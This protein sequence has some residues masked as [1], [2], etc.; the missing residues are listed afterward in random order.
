MKVE[1]STNYEK[2]KFIDFNRSLNEGNVKKL[3][4]LNS[5]DDNYKYF[6]I[7]VS[8]D[9]EIIDGQHRFEACKRTEKPI[10]YLMKDENRAP[11]VEDVNIVNVAGRK[12]TTSDKLV[13]LAKAGDPVAMEVMEACELLD[14]HFTPMCVLSTSLGLASSGSVKTRVQEHNF[15]GVDINFAIDCLNTL[16]DSRIFDKRKERTVVTILRI[17]KNNGLTFKEVVFALSEKHYMLT[18]GRPNMEAQRIQF[19][20]VLNYRKKNKLV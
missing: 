1:I 8:R 17:A 20:E 13:M 14:N 11:T 16:L 19:L 7:V 4:A 18:E 2:F 15:I 9:L 5:L 3:I 6:P 12:H 10:H